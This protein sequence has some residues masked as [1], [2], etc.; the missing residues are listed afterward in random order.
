[1][2]NVLLTCHFI[3][4]TLLQHYNKPDEHIAL[5]ITLLPAAMRVYYW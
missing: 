5:P 2:S 4:P 1:M 3:L